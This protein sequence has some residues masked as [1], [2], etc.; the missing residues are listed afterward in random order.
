MPFTLQDVINQLDREEPNYAQ[1]ARLGSEIIPHLRELIAGDNLGLAA[2]AAFLTGV[3]D[4]EESV[5]VLEIAARHPNPIVPRRRGG[6]REALD[7]P[8]PCAGYDISRGHRSRSSKMGLAN[9]RGHVSRRR[10]TKGGR[11]NAIRH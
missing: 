10:E 8:H 2:K 3:I 5:Q 4:G 7:A 1:A 6:F 9:D 11:D